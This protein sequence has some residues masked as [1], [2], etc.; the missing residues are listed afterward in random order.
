MI[1]AQSSPRELPT[2]EGGQ[3]KRRNSQK[4]WRDAHPGYDRDYKRK[5]R[6]ANP[7]QERE[8]RRKWLMAHPGFEH[9]YNRKWRID[10]PEARLKSKR[11]WQSTWKGKL[12]VWKVNAKARHI[13]WDLSL[14]HLNTLP[15]ICVYTGQALTLDVNQLNTVS[16]DRIDSTK[17]YVPGNVAFCLPSINRMKS[18]Q[19]VSG[20][21]ELCRQV[22]EHAP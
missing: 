19:T 8:T 3:E 17:G 5:W 20:F 21:R 18:D 15:L 22:T 12:K 9:E 2:P 7:E 14:E 11:K 6:A 4:A 13:R 1:T 16:L 10:H